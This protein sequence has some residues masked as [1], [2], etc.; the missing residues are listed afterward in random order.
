[1]YFIALY[2]H[3]YFITRIC[4]ETA[5]A[6]SVHEI[7]P[8]YLR[9]SQPLRCGWWAQKSVSPTSSV[10]SQTCW[11]ILELQPVRP[12]GEQLLQRL[13]WLGRQQHVP[14]CR[15]RWSH[16]VVRGNLPQ[17]SSWRCWHCWWWSEMRMIVIIIFITLPG[18]LN[19]FHNRKH[20]RCTPR[21]E[22][23]IHPLL[24]KWKVSSNRSF[25]PKMP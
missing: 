14:R 7:K 18:I 25:A 5:E 24:S 21:G 17:P 23:L 6:T 1:M 20:T 16:L 11:L 13:Y 19:I 22:G 10:P 15:A 9:N 12:W 3:F 2:C 4:S 8:S